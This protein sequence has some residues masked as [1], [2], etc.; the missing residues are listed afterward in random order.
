MPLTM[1]SCVVVIHRSMKVK[2]LRFLV[3]SLINMLQKV[4]G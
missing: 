2:S 4:E 3:K 1:D